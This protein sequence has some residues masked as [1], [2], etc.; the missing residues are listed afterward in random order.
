MMK[1]DDKLLVVNRI[2]LHKTLIKTSVK[3]KK[4]FSRQEEKDCLS[5]HQQSVNDETLMR[6][7]VP[8]YQYLLSL[9]I[10]SSKFRGLYFQ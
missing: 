10:N 4:H 9:F 7:Q 1:G 5:F 6:I 3:K 8:C 2:V